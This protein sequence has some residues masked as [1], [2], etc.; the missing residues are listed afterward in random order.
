MIQVEPHNRNWPATLFPL[1]VFNE[2]WRERLKISQLQTT[3]VM[4]KEEIPTP[5]RNV[6]LYISPL[7]Y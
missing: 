3:N 6:I 4:A 7:R 2:F 1:N 5:I